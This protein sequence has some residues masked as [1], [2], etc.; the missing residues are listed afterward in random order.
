MTGK[1]QCGR[2]D[3]QCVKGDLDHCPAEDDDFICPETLQPCLTEY[4]EHCEDYGCAR[5]AGIP[6]VDGEWS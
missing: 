5:Q 4:D 6:V 2:P 1:C 3:G